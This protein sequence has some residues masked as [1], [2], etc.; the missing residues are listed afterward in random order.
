MGV[1]RVSYSPLLLMSSFPSILYQC[2]REN[3]QFQ[4]DAAEQRAEENSLRCC[5]GPPANAPQCGM[6][7]Q[8]V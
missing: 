1:Y 3:V 8:G 4:V 2:M 7:P 6:L 5:L